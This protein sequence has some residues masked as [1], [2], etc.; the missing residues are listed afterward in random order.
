MRFFLFCNVT[1]TFL[2]HNTLDILPE[3]VVKCVAVLI[4]C[5][6]EATTIYS[7]VR[8][9]QRVL[10]NALIYVYDN[11][12]NDATCYE[13]KR[14]GA[15][16]RY[17]LKQGKGNVVKSMFNDIN[18]D[19]YVTIDGDMTYNIDD[20]PKMIEM[21][22]NENLDM[23]V[24]ARQKVDK[25]SFPKYHEFGNK[26]Y[27]CLMRLMFGG[28]FTDIFSGFRVLSRDFVKS[29][30]ISSEEFE[31]EAEMTVY[32]LMTKKRCRE[33]SSKYYN[34]PVGSYSKLRSIRDGMKILLKMCVLF[35]QY[36][37]QV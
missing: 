14:A 7:V 36:K 33:I 1:L 5:Y 3:F 15:I 26:V 6:N 32:S 11:S 31:I 13:A 16:V 28:E 22:E 9:F 4:P 12:S 19:I 17:E 18:A 24:A 20:A 29:F 35:F 10:P 37:L 8:R 27:N 23:V 25:N 2:R 30:Q 34:R 21:L